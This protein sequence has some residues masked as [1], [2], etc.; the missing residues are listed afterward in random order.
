MQRKLAIGGLTGFFSLSNAVRFAPQAIRAAPWALS[1]ALIFGGV[2]GWHE[3]NWFMRGRVIMKG[4]EGKARAIGAA[5]RVPLWLVGAMAL[6]LAACEKDGG[7]SDARPDGASKKSS[8]KKKVRGAKAQDVE[9]PD[10][11][12]N[13]EAGLWDGRPSLGGVWVA[14]PDVDQ[15][16][17]VLIRNE[18]NDKSVVGA[19]FRRERESP[20][21]RFQ[22]SSDAAVALDVL[23]GQPVSLNVTALVRAEPEEP[24]E[25]VQEDAA[26][27]AGADEAGKEKSGKEKLGASDDAKADD[28]KAGA[29]EADS[30]QT[31]ASGE[32]AKGEAEQA[33]APVKKKRKWWQRR[34]KPKAAPEAEGEALAAGAAAALAAS[35]VSTSALPPAEPAASAPAPKP[36][37]STPPAPEDG[38]ADAEVEPPVVEERAKSNLSHPYLQIGRYA[39]EAEATEMAARLSTAGYGPQVRQGMRGGKPVWRVV[40]GPLNTRAERTALRRT[41]KAAGLPGGTA[42]RN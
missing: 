39:T 5:G 2:R 1:V 24:E 4:V 32:A 25:V 17:R 22:L 34:E 35:E 15:P 16:E 33:A 9:A 37:A 10:V 30:A 38:L 3:G 8:G 23:A 14:H 42:V 11:F 21:P 6:G 27:E 7:G 28:V 40:L 41:L 13:T 26:P 31:G 18:A 12:Q 20:G 36:S 19:L 29:A